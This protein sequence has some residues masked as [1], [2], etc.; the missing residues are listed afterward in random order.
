MKAVPWAKLL[1]LLLLPIPLFWC[2]LRYYDALSFLESRTLDWRFQARGE[3][4]PPLKVIYADVDSLSIDAI[5]S[6]P[7]SRTY[8]ARVAEA[9]VNEGK[10][11]AVGFDFVFSDIGMA[12]AADL[13]RMVTGNVEFAEFLIKDPPV[14]LAAAYGGWQFTDAL[15]RRQE[16][17][18][19]VVKTDTRK[20]EDVQPPEVPA[21]LISADPDKPSYWNPPFIGM[22]DT[23][24]HGTR[25]VPAY[26]LTATR[27]FFHIS[28]ELARLYWGLPP[29]SLKIAGDEI[30]FVRPGGEL[31]SRVPLRDRQFVEVNW[32]TKWHSSHTAH[33]EFAE[34]YQF[35]EALR[36]DDPE[37]VAAAKEH[38]AAFKD[39]V[40]LIGPVD[41]LLQDVAPTSLDAR[42]VPKVGVHG[43]LLMTVVSGK[44]LRR[45]PAGADYA[46]IV[47]LSLAT[48][49]LVIV[50][51]AKS[52]FAKFAAV[53]L[54]AVYVG[55]AFLLFARGH[56][57]LPIVMP[58]GAALTTSF[59]GLIW[60]VIEEQKAKSRI[61]GMFGTYLAPTVVEQMIA[62][63][64]DP[65]LGGHDAEITAYFSDIQKFSSF[66]EV[67]P[68]AKL[69]E[70]LNEYLTA[71]TDIVQQE[72]G[73]LDKYIGDAVV[74]M[75]GAPLEAPDHAYRACVASQLVQLRVGELRAKWKGEGDKWPELVHNLRTRIGLNTGVCMIGN[76]G[77]RSRFNYTMMGDNVN[78]A[79]RME[80]GAKSW[81]VYTMCTDK[82]RV[83]C[84]QRSDRVVFRPIGR[85]VVQGRSQPVPV[86]EIVGL[87]ENVS[88][89]AR[90][91]IALFEQALARY[92][93]RDWDGAVQLLER[94][95]PLEPN[96]P[97][98]KTGISSNPSLVYLDIVRHAQASPPPPDWDGRYVMTE[99]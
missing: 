25:V 33:T 16:R 48:A 50:G 82:V 81:G 38:F 66:S 17:Q 2:V 59:A 93:A 10:V 74:A 67:L 56:W 3:V 41:P 11:K 15:G 7:W 68:S 61:K 87:K 53:G 40:V 97:N 62:S 28:L 49:A 18:L 27:P 23:M 54:L 12:E 76:M 4:A 44:Y 43:N 73:T 47:L 71:C 35:A 98:K 30:H 6:F 64:R 95:L 37:M 86:H 1:W 42:A 92:Y 26:A 63:G 19:P 5:G 13:R 22:I 14:A 69:G 52:I 60:R 39:A 46:L 31:V 32:F 8:F 21:F 77:S 34:L 91:C 36:S 99:K 96:Q 65:E 57:V 80:S 90:E 75:F 29:G 85:I 89:Q 55:A 20:L 78:L 51:G 84:E 79:A 88:D 24:D 94:S 83:S 9:L 70:L 58:V 45:L 72:M